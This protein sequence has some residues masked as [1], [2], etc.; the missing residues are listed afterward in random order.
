MAVIQQNE[1]GGSGLLGTLGGLASIGG[2]FIPGAQYLT[3]LGFGMGA[4]GSAMNG[5]TQGA[6]GQILSGILSNK[7][8]NPESESIAQSPKM[9]DER[10]FRTWGRYFPWQQ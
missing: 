1:N 9:T 6:M 2:M 3:P 10:L 4:L 8:M 7:L 5:N